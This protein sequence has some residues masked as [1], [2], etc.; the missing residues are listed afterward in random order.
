MIK[1]YNYKNNLFIIFVSLIISLALIEIISRQIYKN[2]LQ[3]KTF[4][5]SAELLIKYPEVI[6][7]QNI[8][9]EEFLLTKKMFPDLKYNNI[10]KIWELEDFQSNCCKII[11]G[12]RFT[13][14]TH[15][16][17][18][19]YIH[20]FGGSTLFNHETPDKYTVASYLQTYINKINQNYNVVN[21]GVFSDMSHTQLI[22]LKNI[23]LKKGDIVIFFGGTN[24]VFFIVQNNR[25]EI[26]DDWIEGHR[27]K[28]NIKKYNLLEKTIL[29]LR[30]IFPKRYVFKLLEKNII[31]LENYDENI[32]LENL[33]YLEK[34]YRE[35]IKESKKLVEKNNAIFYNFLQPNLYVKKKESLS[36]IEQEIIANKEFIS[37]RTTLK[38]Y[39]VLENILNEKPINEFSYNLTN[40]FDVV[41]DEIFVG[42]FIHVNHLGNNIIALS[43]FNII[44]NSLI[45]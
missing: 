32:F 4:F 29:K 35:S 11:D 20:M 13:E 16:N 34:Y 24:D 30:E 25:I 26:G 17:V 43:I 41:D 7:D 15:K 31:G 5:T 45:N 8:Y 42:D 2:G 19:N 37:E 21:H 9:T 1:K 44:K 36:I 12:K 22:R 10:K 40:I 18:K 6:S 14:F 28:K 27:V 23:N 39:S 38:G 33:N 3:E